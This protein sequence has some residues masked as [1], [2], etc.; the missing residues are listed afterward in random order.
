[1]R[2]RYPGPPLVAFALSQ[3]EHLPGCDDE[4]SSLEKPRQ[5]PGW[6]KHSPLSRGLVCSLRRALLVCWDLALWRFAITCCSLSWGWTPQGLA[7]LNQ[8]G[9]LRYPLD[10]PGKAGSVLELFQEKYLLPKVISIHIRA[11]LIRR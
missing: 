6:A 4:A 8:P 11:P 1:M 3:V 10:T 9:I 5:M 2:T 7:L